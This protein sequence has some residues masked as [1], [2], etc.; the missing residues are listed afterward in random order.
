MQNKTFSINVLGNG[1]T[2]LAP[3]FVLIFDNKKYLFNVP[4]GTLRTSIEHKLRLSK[5]NRIFLTSDD[6]SCCGGYHCGYSM[7]FKN[8]TTA[9]PVHSPKSFLPML[10]DC[11]LMPPD[12]ITNISKSRWTIDEEI[13]QDGYLTFTPH[14][15]ISNKIKT[16]SYSITFP[17]LPGKFDAEKA[18]LYGLTGQQRGLLMK[19]KPVT[20]AN[21][22]V[23]TKNDLCSNCSTIGDLLVLHFPTVHHC[24]K[25]IKQHSQRKLCCICAIVSPEVRNHSNFINFIK[26]NS[27]LTLLTTDRIITNDISITHTTAQISNLLC[28]NIETFLPTFTSKYPVNQKPNLLMFNNENICDNAPTLHSFTLFPKRE[29]KS[30][31]QET[32]FNPSEIK[33]TIFERGTK[34]QVKLLGTGGSSTGKLRNVSSSLLQYRN[35]TILI[36]CG[37]TNTYHLIGS[38]VHVDDVDL[39]YIT[40]QHAD[41][42]FG[43]FSFLKYRSKQITIIG[44]RGLEQKL[45]II[46][47][48]VNGRMNYIP[49]QQKQYLKEVK[50]LIKANI[51]TRLLSHS[52]PNFGVRFET[53]LF[54]IVFTGDTTPCSESIKLCKNAD[55]VV[56]ESNFEDGNEDLAIKR[57][58]S[59]PLL[60]EQAL[61]DCNVKAIVLNHIG[62]R[63]T[64]FNA[65]M[66]IKRTIP[67]V[68]GF[69]GMTFCD[70]IIEYHTQYQESLA[71][72]FS[73]N[74]IY[75]NDS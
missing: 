28:K 8:N 1:Q 43:I 33:P 63:T 5:V 58:H 42:Y 35:K 13:V 36:D 18:T 55:I 61:K 66:K 12:N 6:W 68:Y 7:L 39:V 9:T 16:I 73:I 44:P 65:I 46:C 21:G 41:H 23:V 29:N 71:D 15:I 74:E 10:Y 11:G 67:M 52:M 40:H 48:Y 69:D 54:K 72:F 64:K 47:K 31:A 25:F 19:D 57:N 20:L 32:F 62:Q 53:D 14:V 17:K 34:F 3:S 70:K 59:T 37:E 56:H 26:T 22:K 30:I 24:D 38:G 60:I 49:I 51:I 4:E 50:H 27:V 75:E 2:E 45:K